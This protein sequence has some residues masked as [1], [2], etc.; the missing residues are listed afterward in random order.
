MSQL[1]AF[2]LEEWTE[3]LDAVL[4]HNGPEAT[5][6]LTKQLSEHAESARVPDRKSV[7]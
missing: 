1:D 5:G 2:E 3:S 4:R 7:V 6:E